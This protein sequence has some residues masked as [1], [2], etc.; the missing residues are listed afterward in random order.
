MWDHDFLLNPCH[1]SHDIILIAKVIFFYAN[2]FFCIVQTDIS[3]LPQRYSSQYNTHQITDDCDVSKW[4]STGT[5]GNAQYNCFRKYKEHKQAHLY[6][7]AR[8]CLF[9]IPVL[10]YLTK[11]HH[12]LEIPAIRSLQCDICNWF[13]QELHH[14]MRWIWIPNKFSHPPIVTNNRK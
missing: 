12:C 9:T 6:G 11:G 8:P 2:K 3:T 7:H 1:K 13:K 5:S 10:N 14:H 4:M